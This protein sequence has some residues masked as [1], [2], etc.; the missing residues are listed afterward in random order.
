MQHKF[1]ADTFDK[2]IEYGNE[3]TARFLKNIRRSFV[4]LAG[5]LDLPEELEQIYKEKI[6]NGNVHGKIITH[7]LM[8][9]VMRELAKKYKNLEIFYLPYREG[10]H[11]SVGDD[12]SIWIENHPAGTVGSGKIYFGAPQIGKRYKSCFDELKK[13]A[14]RVPPD[15]IDSVF[16]TNLVLEEIDTEIS[17]EFK[18]KYLNILATP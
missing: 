11:F 10:T 14:V 8:S 3:K 6:I 17:R 13:D 7:R 4:L 18:E 12:E 2:S 15:Q 1:E 9:P 16:P 5:E